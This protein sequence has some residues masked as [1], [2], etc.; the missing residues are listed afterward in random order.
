MQYFM[1]STSSDN[2]IILF[3]APRHKRTFKFSPDLVPVQVRCS[4]FRLP[5]QKTS[6]RSRQT[7]R[8]L[9]TNVRFVRELIQFLRNGGL[10]RL[11][12]RMR[13]DKRNTTMETEVVKEEKEVLKTE[14]EVEMSVIY[15]MRSLVYAETMRVKFL[16]NSLT[17]KP[18][19]MFLQRLQALKTRE[20][21]SRHLASSLFAEILCTSTTCLPKIQF[22]HNW[23]L[24]AC[25]SRRS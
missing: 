16:K 19:F 25:T 22:T 20:E 15:G 8:K 14:T 5:T 3:R 9:E 24:C 18:W 17:M 23:K 1:F 7:R 2:K 21:S 13:M 10:P 4:K 11:K 6:L 12:F